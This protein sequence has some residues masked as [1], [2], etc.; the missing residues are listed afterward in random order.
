MRIDAMVRRMGVAALGRQD[1][2]HGLA[3][4][5]LARVFKLARSNSGAGIRGIWNAL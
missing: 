2:K 5:A 3:V 4:N 1:P